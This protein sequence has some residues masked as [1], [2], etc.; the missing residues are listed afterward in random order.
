ML[1]Y[2]VGLFFWQVTWKL[3]NHFALFVSYIEFFCWVSF[4]PFFIWPLNMIYERK[5]PKTFFATPCPCPLLLMTFCVKMWTPHPLGTKNIIHHA[6]WL[7]YRNPLNYYKRP[8]CMLSTPSPPPPKRGMSLLSILTFTISF[9]VDVFFLSI[10]LSII[11]LF[12]DK[13]EMYFVS[14]SLCRRGMAWR[15]VW[16]NRWFSMIQLYSLDLWLTYE[17]DNNWLWE[18]GND[19]L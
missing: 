10:Q 4:C 1:A 3:I 19:D 15:E 2:N 9:W 7:S 11:R 5:K 18:Y 12:M 14:I 16:I 17:L 13:V 8:S 6:Y